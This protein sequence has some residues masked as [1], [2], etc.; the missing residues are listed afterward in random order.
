MSLLKKRQQVI[1]EI[2]ELKKGDPY[3]DPAY[4]NDNADIA[5]DVQED[6]SHQTVQAEI[7]ALRDT[8]SLVEI[9][10]KKIDAGTYGI[11]ERTGEIIPEAR[12]RLVPE[13]REIVESE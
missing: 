3:S 9:A 6:I 11:C 4:A 1:Q 12:L 2:T 5:S 10:L 8:L 7:D 13:A